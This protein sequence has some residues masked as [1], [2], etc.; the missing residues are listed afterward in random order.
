MNKIQK[1]QKGFAHYETLLLLVI[2]FLI[3]GIGWYVWHVKQQADKSLDATAGLNLKTD[4]KK[5]AA[6]TALP[7]SNTNKTLKTKTPNLVSYTTTTNSNGLNVQSVADVDKLDGASDS[8]KDFVKSKVKDHAN[9][10]S[11]C[12][13]AYGL[14]VKKIYQ[15][16]FAV[17]DE[18]Q[19]NNSEKLWAKI[20]DNWSEIA[21]SQN[22][23]DC[24]VLEQYKVPSAI[25]ANCTKNG[26]QIP[27]TQN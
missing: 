15:D 8:F 13:N 23:F 3:F 27:N 26:E 17:V 18:K 10:P 5:K 20:S 24:T 4:T 12:G 22:G 2:I 16:N 1:S 19:C 6:S 25:V 11:P 21:T 9:S 7:T 14:F